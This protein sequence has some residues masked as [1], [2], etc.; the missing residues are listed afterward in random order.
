MAKAD[1]Y[2]FI[3]KKQ[4]KNASTSDKINQRT[5]T[6]VTANGGWESISNAICSNKIHR[7]PRSRDG[8]WILSP[9]IPIRHR[10]HVFARSIG[11]LSFGTRT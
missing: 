2:A 9:T 6:S 11:L 4:S 1:Q 8:S 7:R 3:P 10:I 5:E